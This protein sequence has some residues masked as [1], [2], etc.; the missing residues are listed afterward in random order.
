MEASDEITSSGGNREVDPHCGFVAVSPRMID[1]RQ[2]FKFL[3]LFEQNSPRSDASQT[4][5][6]FVVVSRCKRTDSNASKGVYTKI[7]RQGQVKMKPA[8]RPHKYCCHAIERRKM[9]C[10]NISLT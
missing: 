6:V 8:V 1:R 7:E 5:Q 4:V 3:V 2:P 10:L 9:R